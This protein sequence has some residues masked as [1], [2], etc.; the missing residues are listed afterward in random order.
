MAIIRPSADLRNKY[1]E[2]SKLCHETKQPVYITKNGA[3]DLV[4][5]SNEAYEELDQIPGW[6]RV[7]KKLDEEFDRRYP[8]F[9][10]FEK[11][12]IKKIKLAL[13]QS[14]NGETR[15][16]EEFFKEMEEKYGFSE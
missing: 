3:N 4:L 16:A 12:V 11:D 1:N 8:T 5:L 7:S 10:D 14:E 15:P 13:K 9:E 6:D 2:I